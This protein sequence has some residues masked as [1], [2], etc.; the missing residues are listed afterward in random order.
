MNEI[1]PTKPGPDEITDSGTHWVDSASGPRRIVTPTRNPLPGP[2]LD[3]GGPDGYETDPIVGEAVEA[4]R[5]FGDLNR[6]QAS[7]IL[8]MWRYFKE[9]TTGEM[10]AATRRFPA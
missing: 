6:D 10:L 4:L 1:V 9:L 5:S 2:V 7:S 3:G 8:P